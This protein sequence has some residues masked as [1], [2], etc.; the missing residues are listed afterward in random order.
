MLNTPLSS[1]P[2]G[3]RALNILHRN[4]IKIVENLTKLEPH[5][6]CDFRGF[7]PTCLGEVVRALNGLGLKLKERTPVV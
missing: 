3:N 4:D 6:L 7:G 2:I 5:D 1:L